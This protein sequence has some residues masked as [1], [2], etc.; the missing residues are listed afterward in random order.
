MT[1]SE[2]EMKGLVDP[3]P[4]SMSQTSC[5]RKNPLRWKSIN[6]HTHAHIHTHTHT[7]THTLTHTHTYPPHAHIHT[8]TYTHTHI[9]YK[10][11]FFEKSKT[12]VEA[13]VYII[14]FLQ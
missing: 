5:R 11:I 13:F 4:Y 1:S 10:C 2:T 9:L 3:Y 8:H 7:H 14:E 6:T 12:S